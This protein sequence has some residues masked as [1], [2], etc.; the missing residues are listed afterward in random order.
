MNGE[1]APRTDCHV[2]NVTV[3]ITTPTRIV[4][5]TS[6]VVP[7]TADAWHTRDNSN[8]LRVALFHADVEILVDDLSASPLS[9]HSAEVFAIDQATGINRAN[10]VV[11]EFIAAD[12]EALAD[13][14]QGGVFKR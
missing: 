10:P 5:A 8:G 3:Q 9:L 12:R 2:T 4:T 6:R 13:L 11:F 7:Q 1:L 14:N